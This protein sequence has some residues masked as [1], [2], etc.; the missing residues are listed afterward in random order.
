MTTPTPLNA[1]NA[2]FTPE[3][4]CQRPN[5]PYAPPLY[6]YRGALGAWRCPWNRTLRPTLQEGRSTLRIYLHLLP[7]EERR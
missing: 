5:A 4:R 1:L 3:G 2:L 6:I 7:A